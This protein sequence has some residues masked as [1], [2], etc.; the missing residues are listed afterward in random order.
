MAPVGS[1]RTEAG[2]PQAAK[3]SW[4]L[5]TTSAALV[6]GEGCPCPVHQQKEDEDDQLI[7]FEPRGRCRRRRSCGLVG[8]L[9]GRKRLL[10]CLGGLR[11]T[12]RNPFGGSEHGWHFRT[13][14]KSGVSASL[15]RYDKG[16]CRQVEY[17]ASV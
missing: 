2:N 16:R 1:V 17:L 4:K 5:L 10:Q 9:D 13:K 14:Y 12:C 7:R 11:V 15:L 3:P 8:S 6:V